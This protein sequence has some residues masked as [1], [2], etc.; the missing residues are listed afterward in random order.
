M[1]KWWLFILFTI[2]C[3]SGILAQVNSSDTFFLSAIPSQGILL[4]KEW[5]F[6]GGDNV[7]WAQPGYQDSNWIPSDPT[8]ELHHLPA[9]RQAGIGWFR[10]K[11][12][13]DSSLLGKTFAFI[14][15]TF[16]ASEIY[17]NGKLV[18]SFGI[19]S[20]DYN[21][22]LT[23]YY[24][25]RLLS[26]KL[27]NQRDQTI[28]IRYSFN[29]KNFYLRFTNARPV[30]RLVLKKIDKAF[31]DHIKNDSFDSTLRSIQVSFY[32]PLGFLLLFLFF[33]F[34]LQKEYLYSGI[35]CL[36]MFAA[37]LMHIFALDEPITASH[38]IF[39]L[40]ITQVLYLV[41]ALSFINGAYI[42][43]NQKKG[44]NYYIILAYGIFSLVFFFFSYDYSGILNACF[45][46]IITLEFF[47]INLKMMRKGRKGSF[48]LFLTSLT[49]TGSL[50]LYIW[51]TLNGKVESSALL[52][53]VSFLIPGIGLSLF[54]AGE[55][56]RT[57]SLLR[58]R[59]IEVEELSKEMISK[60]REKQQILSTHNEMLEKQVTE[61]TAALTQSLNNLKDAQ[62]QLIQQ[63]KMASL[64]ELTAGIAH[65]IQNPLNFVNNFS[66]VNA[67]LIGE[68]KNELNEGNTKEAIIIANTIEENEQKIS[69]HGKRA[70]AIVKGMIQHSRKHSG[71]EELTN[72]N[73][74]ADEYLRLSYHGFR[75]KDK[76]FE[77]TTKTDFDETLGKINIVPQ[78]I[79][80]VLLNLYNNAFYAV[81]EKTKASIN[82]SAQSY[83]PTVSVSTKK[84]NEK[85]EIRVKDNGNGIPQ[86]I[87]DKI[88]QPFFTTK[89]TGQG[90]GLGLSLSYDIIKA[91]AGE[92]KLETGEGEGSRF[93]IQ[94]PVN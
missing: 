45:F 94:L 81:A 23:R 84:I 53:S 71:Q 76:S 28:A 88:F 87:V 72:L 70:D 55:F 21:K 59:A 30:A 47:R 85:V 4:N 43:Y 74:L 51:F 83:Q 6:H 5:K 1:A 61:R 69:Q 80:R 16:G 24:S 12:H 22:E 60:E 42:L 49:L 17:L 78:D 31:A 56:A 64:G 19:V 73:E 52:Q 36:C 57:A 48:I 65:E 86:N 91:H 92:I 20:V 68:M 11:L 3:A 9:V 39:L 14:V 35:F 77:V 7:Q 75:A 54:F 89:P 27:G 2:I 38:S 63:E 32:L 67:D 90:T 58:L 10:L 93:I 37:I 66:E 62:N 25:N 15:S 82:S 40:L 33:S 8:E 50:L 46:P 34:R 13:V 18:Y 29:R 26:L 44:I 79:G 41:G